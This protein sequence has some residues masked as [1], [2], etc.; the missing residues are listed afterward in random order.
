[1]QAA[2][3]WITSYN[4]KN[5][6]KG[7]RKRFK[8]DP[9]CAADELQMLGIEISESRI[10]QLR[11]DEENHRK[12]RE[13]RRQH[14]EQ[15]KLMESFPC[16]DGYHYFI[17]GYTSGGAPYGITW[18]ETGLEPFAEIGPQTSLLKLPPE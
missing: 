6:I 10:Q 17:A 14:K 7:Y 8:V 11:R 15:Q 5:I 4:G 9:L 16:S 18:E 12:Q 3:H 2:T 13:L 1:M